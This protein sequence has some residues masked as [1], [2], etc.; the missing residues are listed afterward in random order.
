LV[1]R[2]WYVVFH[3]VPVEVLMFVNRGYV[4]FSLELPMDS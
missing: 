1:Y 2:R 3:L 4:F